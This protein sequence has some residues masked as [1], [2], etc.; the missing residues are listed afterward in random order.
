LTT[1]LSLPKGFEPAKIEVAVKPEGKSFRSFEQ[2]FD[3]KPS[4]A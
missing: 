4:D 3:W 2:S 1:D